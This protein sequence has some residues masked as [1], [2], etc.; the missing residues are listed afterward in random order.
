MTIRAAYALAG[1]PVIIHH[2]GLLA[3]GLYQPT[4]K[5]EPIRAISMPVVQPLHPLDRV[6][7]EDFNTYPCD[8]DVPESLRAKLL[9]IPHAAKIK[10]LIED[11]IT[12][13]MLEELRRAF[14]I[15]IE[16][17]HELWKQDQVEKRG[18]ITFEAVWLG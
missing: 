9:Y 6:R 7:V 16:R 17:F 10:P 5:P 3:A 13:T 18:N 1:S 2:L 12:R 14:E 4:G 8:S 11:K 15:G